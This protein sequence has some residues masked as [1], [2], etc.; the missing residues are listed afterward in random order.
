M[1]NTVIVCLITLFSMQTHG[2]GKLRERMSHLLPFIAP[3]TYKWEKKKKAQL[4][5]MMT[6]LSDLE[7]VVLDME[8]KGHADNIDIMDEMALMVREEIYGR[9]FQNGR[10]SFLEILNPAWKTQLDSILNDPKK[11]PH[12]FETLQN[13][14]QKDPLKKYR[15]ILEEF[16]FANTKDIVAVDSTS[17]QFKN[18]KKAIY[19]TD[20]STKILQE[21]LNKGRSTEDFFAT[22]SIVALPNPSQAYRQALNRFFIDNTEDIVELN[23]SPE[24]IER[25]D[26]YVRIV[27]TGIMFLKLA[28][29]KAEGD[30]DRFFAV[31]HAV[32]TPNPSQAYRQA[33]NRFFIDNTEDIVELN[34]SPEQIERIDHYVRIIDTGIMFLKLALKKAEGDADRFFAVFHSVA[35]PNP[36]QAYRQAL[37]R[38]FIDNTEDIVELNFSPEQIERIDH[39]VRIIDT[40]IMFLKLALKKAEGDADRFFAVFHSVAIPNPTQAYR[41]ALNRFFIDNTE[42]IVELNFS[43]E[44]IERID[45]YVDKTETSTML[46]RGRKNREVCAAGVAILLA[47]GPLPENTESEI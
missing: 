44:Q 29:K 33:L 41:Q 8:L 17:K 30:A 20:I 36:T 19:T 47:S 14:T 5:K 25:I 22:F 27:D 31:F 11:T 16:F 3:K 18:I 43:P 45:R 13:F 39:Y 7:L 23:F 15:N 6:S 38:F 21:M 28:L 32:A 37:N 1:K 10:A 24:Q 9:V 4:T 40:G 42:D 26:H 2:A 12:S 46:L 34:F 35:I